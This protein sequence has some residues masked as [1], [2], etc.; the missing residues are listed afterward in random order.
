MEIKLKRIYDEA[1]ES[2]GFRVLVDRLWPRGVK[3][4]NARV[5]LWVKTIAPTTELRKWFNHDVSKWDEFCRRY[6]Q[7]LDTNPDFASFADTVSQ[8]P[9]VTFLFG[10]KDTEHNNAV[11]L[12]QKVI[13]SFELTNK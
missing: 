13:T 9:V 6:K 8:H 4:D 1:S 10:A 2:D 12:K 3:K 7:E 5:D 11:V